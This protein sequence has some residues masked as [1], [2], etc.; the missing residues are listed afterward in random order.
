MLVFGKTSIIL[1]HLETIHNNATFMNSSMVI[2]LVMSGGQTYFCQVD[3]L[4]GLTA[5]ERAMKIMTID[6]FLATS[7]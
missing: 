4:V 7:L 6:R 2:M 3:V 5:R 1:R